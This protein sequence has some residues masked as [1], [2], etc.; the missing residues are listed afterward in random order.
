MAVEI[1]SIFRHCSNITVF[2]HHRW[3]WSIAVSIRPIPQC[4]EKIKC[5]LDLINHYLYKFLIVCLEDSYKHTGVLV[6]HVHCATTL[7]NY[8]S[9]LSFLKKN[10][11]L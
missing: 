1:F 7:L 5:H 9:D 8:I 10:E 4:T 3:L 6:Y 11:N 2:K